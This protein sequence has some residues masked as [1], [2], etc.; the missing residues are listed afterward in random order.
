MAKI[1]CSKPEWYYQLNM[2]FFGSWEQELEEQKTDI[3]YDGPANYLELCDDPGLPKNSN[4]LY[5]VRLGKDLYQQYYYQE[6]KWFKAKE[7]NSGLYEFQP[8]NPKQKTIDEILKA[9]AKILRKDFARLKYFLEFRNE[10]ER[11]ITR[12]IALHMFKINKMG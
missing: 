9:P 1:K 6:N 12:N 11:N 3:R 4:I 10:T 2:R 8:M 7:L 5:W